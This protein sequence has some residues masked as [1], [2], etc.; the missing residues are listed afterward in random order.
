MDK[1]QAKEI[2][3]LYRPGTADGLEPDVAAALA[4]AAK[5]VELGRWL[6]QHCATQETI[7]ASF[8]AITVPEG[9]KQQILSER[10]AHFS[11]HVKRKAAFVL[12]AVALALALGTIARLNYHPPQ[13]NSFVAFRQ[14]MAGSMLRLPYPQ[15]DVETNNLV[16]IRRYLAAHNG[17]GDYSL[18]V[19]L[20]KTK[21]TGCKIMG[22]HDRR[23]SMVCFSSGKQVDPE[24]IDLFLFIVDR[25]AVKSP[26]A[27]ASP[28]I[29]QTYRSMATASWSSG[30]RS[31]VLAGLGDTEFLRPYLR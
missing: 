12:A 28:E 18:P 3:L 25:T 21:S 8:K 31:Y 7:R 19:T 1:H 2:L 20:E 4:L 13:D 5:D 27:S 6:E 15:M 24:T 22:W 29:A 23:V 26:P 16:V 10:R 11:L 17:H 9:L 30:N 14:K